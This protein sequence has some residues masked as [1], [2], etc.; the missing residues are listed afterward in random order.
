M[1]LSV[2]QRDDL[3]ERMLPV[4]AQV[5]GSVR[6]RDTDHFQTLVSPL[7]RD[8]LLALLIDVA[9]MVPD[10]QTVAELVLWTH[11]PDVSD[12]Q[13]QQLTAFQVRPG[14]KHCSWCREWWRLE[15]FQRSSSTKDGRR[16]QC[17][18]CRAER[19]R[20]ETPDDGEVAA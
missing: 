11:G 15:E 8:Q 14:M 20:A 6:T 7:D 9:A 16:S 18:A 5:V 3:L 13:Y 17:R 19:G 4:A 2:E 1:S 12:E 10:D